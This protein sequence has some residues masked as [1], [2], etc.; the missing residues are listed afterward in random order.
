[1]QKTEAG[2]EANKEK[3]F[4]GAH[5]RWMQ[6]NEK[7]LERAHLDTEFKC[8]QVDPKALAVYAN[9]GQPDAGK[10]SE[11]LSAS[12][13]RR[14]KFKDFKPLASQSVQQHRGGHGERLSMDGMIT[15]HLFKQ[16]TKMNFETF[17]AYKE[18][19]KHLPQELK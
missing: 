6:A 12:L 4:E 14:M 8:Q 18:P 9:R 19:N 5:Q 15:A 11:G 1:M 7:V 16:K 10:R 17:F 2:V 13:T 3:W